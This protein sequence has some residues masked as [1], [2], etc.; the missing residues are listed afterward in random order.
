MPHHPG[1]AL[2]FEVIGKAEPMTIDVL[3]ELRVPGNH[4]RYSTGGPGIHDRRR[5]A[6]GHHDR[7][8]GEQIAELTVG[9]DRMT[10]DP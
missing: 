3:S 9:Y 5:A 7:G 8:V 1:Q 2:T 6:M 10:L 4:D